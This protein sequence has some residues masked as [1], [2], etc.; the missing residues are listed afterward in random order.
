MGTLPIL[1][2]NARSKRW[3]RLRLLILVKK[4]HL[5]FIQEQTWLLNDYALLDSYYSYIIVWIGTGGCIN[6]HLHGVQI[7]S[8]GKPINWFNLY[9]TNHKNSHD[10]WPVNSFIKVNGQHLICGDF[11]DH[12][13]HW[14]KGKLNSKG[15]DSFKDYINS[16]LI[17]L[18]DHD[19]T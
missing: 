5:S 12:F 11:N 19:I 7:I 18:N 3:I 8:L 10:F 1:N 13:P 6:M 15:S 16:S 4:M 2:W 17:L 14:C 9:A